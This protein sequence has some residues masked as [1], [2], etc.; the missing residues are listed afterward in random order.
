MGQNNRADGRRQEGKDGGR[1]QEMPLL[2][3]A[4]P[5]VSSCRSS[6]PAAYLTRI[7]CGLP[8]SV[9]YDQSMIAKSR[10]TCVA[11]SAP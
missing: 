10:P 8:G 4:A 2:T 6:V 3:P 5:V 9:W 11:R 1:H 7:N